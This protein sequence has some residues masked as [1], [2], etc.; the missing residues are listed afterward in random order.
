MTAASW[1]R[2]PTPV[3]PG[4]RCPTPTCSPAPTRGT[5]SSSFSNPLAGLQAWCST[6]SLHQAIADVS[7]LAGQTAQ[8]RM[9]L[10]SDS[11][12][13]DVGWDVDDVTVQS[14]Q[15]AGRQPRRRRRVCRRPPRQP[16]PRCRPRRRRPTPQ[17]RRPRP[18]RPRL[19]RPRPPQPPRQRPRRPA[20]S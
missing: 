8:F 7:S 20:W 11:S 1:K 15:P 5:V 4:H 6:T 2:R 19:C 12:V 9:R 10:G 16:T 18:Q 14:C 3:R 17:C 13:S